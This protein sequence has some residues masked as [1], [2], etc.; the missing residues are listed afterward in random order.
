MLYSV[1]VYNFEREHKGPV[2]TIARGG[3]MVLL[4]DSV[5]SQVMERMNSTIQLQVQ[6]GNIL[7][8]EEMYQFVAKL[9]FSH[10]TCLSYSKS[11]D[12]LKRV[13]W[14]VPSLQIV[15]WVS[16]YI[17]G[18]SAS[19]RGDDGSPER[20]CQSNVIPNLTKFEQLSFCETR[21]LL[22]TRLISLQH[23][24][25]IYLVQGQLSIR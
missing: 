18:F 12:L 25:T 23:S 8:K 6:D 17:R 15:W 11:I 1:V 7:T 22:W 5:L 3:F 20:I 13:G 16:K 9:L 19:G 24:T 4:M 2:L 21:K 10:T 14:Y